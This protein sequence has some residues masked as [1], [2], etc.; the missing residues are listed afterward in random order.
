MPPRIPKRDPVGVYVRKVTAQR[1]L[2]EGAKCACG[3]SQP[4]ALI[5]KGNSVACA[6]CVR[7]LQGKTTMD[8]HHIA[9]RSN[10]PMVIAVNV[11]HHRACLSTEQADWPKETLENPH[12]CP[13]RAAAACVRGFID[14]VIFLIKET[15]LWVAN[16]LEL[17]SNLLVEKFGSRWWVG[18][19]LEQFA[20]QEKKN[21]NR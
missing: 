18:T 11:N 8:K 15:L 9:G 21:D 20:P 3:E 14:L 7:K 2:G 4:E 17:L 6:T 10:H 13:L 1:R 19:D 12:G 5:K 16:M